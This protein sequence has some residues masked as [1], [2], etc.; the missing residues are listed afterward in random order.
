MYNI[1]YYIYVS[2]LSQSRDIF[3]AKDKRLKPLDLVHTDGF[4]GINGVNVG[5]ERVNKYVV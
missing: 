1:K 4:N 3:R 5:A 2:P